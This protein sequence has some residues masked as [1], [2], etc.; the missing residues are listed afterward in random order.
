MIHKTLLSKSANFVDGAFNG[1]FIEN[2]KQQ[3]ELPDEQPMMFEV[4]YQ[5][6]YTEKLHAKE[7]YTEDA[8]KTD[9]FWLHVF[10]MADRLLLDELSR[11]T[12]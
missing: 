8:I 6:L 12:Y 11:E 4:F 3:V 5:W 2:Q 1:E 9:L 7:A 10:A